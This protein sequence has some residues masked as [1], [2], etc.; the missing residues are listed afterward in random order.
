MA[1]RLLGPD[2]EPYASA[3]PGRFGG[4]RRGRG[5]GRLDCTAALRAIARGGYVAHRVFFADEETAVRAGYRPCGICLRDRYAAWK[6]GTPRV[7]LRVDGP[8]DAGHALSFLSARAVPGL[9]RVEG[10]RYRRRDVVVELGGADVEVWIDGRGDDPR[11]AFARLGDAV[12]GVRRLLGLDRDVAAATRALATDPLLGLLVRA[13]PGLRPCGAWSVR[14]ATLRAVVG[15]QVSVAGA[16]TVLGRL[17]ADDGELSSPAELASRP[18]EAFP[19]PRSRIRALQ[20]LAALD[21]TSEAALRADPD[22]FAEALLASPGIGPWTVA[23]VRLR[24]LGDDDAWP[25]TDLL[26]QRAVAAS[27]ADPELWRPWRAWAAT[28]LWADA[29]RHRR[30]PKQARQ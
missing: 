19:M 28:Y 12:P 15:Q 11:S 10:S 3:E 26:L 22:A 5:Y 1:Y 2:R 20:G 14:E 16:R 24:G 4:H 17:I 25:G 18:I 9:E 6:A 13:R 30:A 29:A 8:W 23:Y 7:A 21:W 27:G